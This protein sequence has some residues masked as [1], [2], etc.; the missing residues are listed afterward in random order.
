MLSLW[1]FFYFG[2]LEGISASKVNAE[3]VEFLC[4][5]FFAE[6]QFIAEMMLIRL[7]K[8][9]LSNK[10]NHIIMMP[11]KHSKHSQAISKPIKSFQ[12]IPSNVFVML[13]CTFTCTADVRTRDKNQ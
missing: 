3:F 13:F 7:S 6:I 4:V 8:A 10:F 9:F 5:A 12:P 2:N 1:V 11:P